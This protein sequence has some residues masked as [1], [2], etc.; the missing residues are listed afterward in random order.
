MP[1]HRRI[2]PLSR[3]NR[4]AIFART[5]ICVSRVVAELRHLCREIL[6][7]NLM[8]SSSALLKGE[9]SEDKEPNFETARMFD[10]RV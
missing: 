9:A 4:P 5:A 6:W 1:G 7:Q 2:L 8:Q 10:Q 3:R